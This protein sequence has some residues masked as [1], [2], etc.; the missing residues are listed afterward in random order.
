MKTLGELRTA[1][2]GLIAAH[3]PDTNV[4]FLFQFGSGRTSHAP[5]TGYTVS[6]GQLTRVRFTVGYAR[7]KDAAR[8]TT[9]GTGEGE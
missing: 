6:T 7:G 2:D 1:V 5:V 4:D 8:P 9:P 3:G